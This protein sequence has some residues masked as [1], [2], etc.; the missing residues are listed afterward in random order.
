MLILFKFQIFVIES[1]N[2]FIN[3]YISVCPYIYYNLIFPFTSQNVCS[4]SMLSEHLS[5]NILI[6]FHLRVSNTKQLFEWSVSGWSALLL[7]I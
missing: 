3:Y 5:K 7:S 6:Y 4:N 1:V 2:I